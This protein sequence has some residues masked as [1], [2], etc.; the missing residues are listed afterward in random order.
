MSRY[1]VSSSAMDSKQA[2]LMGKASGLARRQKIAAETRR[3]QLMDQVIQGSADMIPDI[4]Y[5]SAVKLMGLV[6]ESEDIPV[7][8]T[9]DRQR[10][11]E[12]AKTLF[13]I[14]RLAS[15]ESTQNV[16]H[17]NVNDAALDTIAERVAKL[18][19]GA[20]DVPS[21]DMDGPKAPPTNA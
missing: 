19:S 11:V 15:G 3:R 18:R 10:T 13:Q 1:A 7:E 2:Q 5:T 9:L 17:A 6:L 4:A 16:L 20:I 14:G 21:D 12:A 8:T